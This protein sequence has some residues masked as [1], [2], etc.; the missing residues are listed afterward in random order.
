M[1]VVSVHLADVGVRSGVGLLLRGAR[2]GPVD[3]LRHADLGAAAPLSGSLLRAPRVGR[4]CLIAFWDNNEAVDRF[5]LAH[6]L[7][8]RL[9]GGWHARLEPLRH[10][11][12]W[13]GLP[14]S[15]PH[16]R[17][18]DYDGPAA[19]V[20]LG[21]LRLRR[22]GAFLQASTRAEAAALTA[23]GALWATAVARLPFVAT[24]SLW[25]S[26]QAL[27]DYAYGTGTRAHLD[28]VERDA[29]NPFHHRS[30]FVR[31]RPYHVEGRLGGLN[32]LNEHLLSAGRRRG[33]GSGNG[34]QTMT[35]EATAS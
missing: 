13:P 16:S 7:A 30:A 2:L 32:P 12:S 27:T 31:F 8:R 6:P 20:T 4:I 24:C 34:G 21:R 29:A 15:L 23:R 19:V 22:A 3:G 17:H 1:A 11:G 10:F 18:I 5:M 25:A 28:A 26:T 9:S 33:T 14:E 35:S